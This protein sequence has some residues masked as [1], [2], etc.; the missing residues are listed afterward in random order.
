MPQY[1]WTCQKSWNPPELMLI[2]FQSMG[3]LGLSNKVV[4]RVEC[5]W[6]A[7][8]LQA[9]ITAS[10]LIG[11]SLIFFKLLMSTSS[12]VWVSSMMS[13]PAFDDGFQ[14]QQVL[15]CDGVDI[16]FVY[17]SSCIW[18]LVVSGS[19]LNPDDD[20]VV[21]QLEPDW[22]SARKPVCITCILQSWNNRSTTCPET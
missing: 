21:S 12:Y 8:S 22:S 16:I 19:Q 5:V 15:S 10:H 20:P 7:Y 2:Y 17:I 9:I 18:E 6:M 1:G 11:T 4:N 14:G 13:P 3:G